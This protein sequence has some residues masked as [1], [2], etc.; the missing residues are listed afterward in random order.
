MANCTETDAEPRCDKC[1]AELTT[2]L[3]AAFCEK[4]KGCEFY[5]PE[6]DDFMAEFGL[7]RK[8]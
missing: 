1:G 6:P 8:V 7:V 5:V 3:M 4:G 2:G